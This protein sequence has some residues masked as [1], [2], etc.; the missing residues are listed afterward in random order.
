MSTYN[1]QDSDL[2]A[3]LIDFAKSVGVTQAARISPQAVQV[4]SRL[5]AYCRDPK[6]PHFGQSMSC[7]PHVSGPVGFRKLLAQSRH[8]LVLRIEVD[9]DSLH[10]ENRPE[11]MRLLHTL[12]ASVE[13][14]ARRLGF[15]YAQGFAGGSCKISFCHN[16][17]S[18][19]VLAKEGE[20]RFPDQARQS[21]S[22]F[23]VNVGELMK[24]AGWSNNLFSDENNSKEQLAWVAGLIL[25]S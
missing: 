11:V 13:S 22:G 5:A 21:M 23:G 16:Y 7:P 2:L 4:E 25:L 20:C 18:C 9:S 8:A 10:G 12:T 3:K 19:A 24:E 15:E 6:C 14:E 17:E 1:Q